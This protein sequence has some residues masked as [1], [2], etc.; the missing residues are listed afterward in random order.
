MVPGTVCTV[1]GHT[2]HIRIQ[3]TQVQA[4]GHTSWATED[5]HPEP[6]SFM[7][8]SRSLSIRSVGLHAFD[9][10]TPASPKHPVSR[11]L[12]VNYVAARYAFGSRA[13]TLTARSSVHDPRASSPRVVAQPSSH[14][15]FQIFR[16]TGD[17]SCMF[18]A[19][20][21]GAQLAAKGEGNQQPA[22][23]LLCHEAVPACMH[24]LSLARWLSSYRAPG[25][26]TARDGLGLAIGRIL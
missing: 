13:D 4:T 5:S 8:T 14:T 7:F 1:A 23:S 24:V 18:R 9:R 15:S 19:I 3:V 22:G 11:L 2:S 17:G 20:V 26:L 25:L 6:R 12:L 21:Q 10:R 16:V